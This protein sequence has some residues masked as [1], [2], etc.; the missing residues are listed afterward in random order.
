MRIIEII[1]QL[2]SGGGER[3]T[4]DLCNE[5][6]KSND[7]TLIVF[8]SLEEH[9]FYKD[10]LSPRVKIISLNK[11]IGFDFWMSLRV[12]FLILKLTPDI[13]HSHLGGIEYLFFSAIFY[14][15]PK[16]FHTVHSDAEKEASGG[17]GKLIRRIAFKTGR[18]KPVTISNTSEKSFRDFYKISGNLIYNGRKVPDRIVIDDAIKSEFLEY[19]KNGRVITI[20]AT[21]TPVKRHVVLAKVARRLYENGYKFSL[22]MIGRQSDNKIVDEVRSIAPSCVYILGQKHDTLQYLKMSDAF[23]LCSEYEG[24]PISLIE[25]L[26]CGAVPLCTPVGGIPDLITDGYNGVLSKD[27]SEESYYE[28]FIRLLKMSEAELSQMRQRALESS[29]T[30]TIEECAMN[31][32]RLFASYMR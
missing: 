26:I 11:R 14:W 17:I 6:A 1:P 4:V 8:H 2:S 19:R 3:F 21:F 22:L 10:E 15:H 7:L 29:R 20:I 25:A 12:L 5:L 27:L 31:Y 28:A 23:C 32:L 24:M 9:G 30:L 13:V 18:I 16:Y